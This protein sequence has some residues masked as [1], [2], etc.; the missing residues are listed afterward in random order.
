[1]LLVLN[2]GVTYPLFAK[3]LPLTLKQLLFQVVFR[4][5]FGNSYIY[6]ANLP[7]CTKHHLFIVICKR[8]YKDPSNNG[9]LSPLNQYNTLNSVNYCINSKF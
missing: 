7:V 8:I 5:R 2:K 1:M 9:P 3:V 6:I 4:L